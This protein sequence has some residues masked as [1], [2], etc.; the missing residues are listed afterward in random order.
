ME[1]DSPLGA[2]I[3]NLEDSVSIS[4]TTKK[5]KEKQRG[6]FMRFMNKVGL[7]KSMAKSSM[8]IEVAEEK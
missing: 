2:D 3:D 1:I 5:K 7:K 8:K 4:S 6:T